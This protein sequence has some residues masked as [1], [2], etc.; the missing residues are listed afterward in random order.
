M[1]VTEESRYVENKNFNSII[2]NINYIDSN[3]CSTQIS[4]S[5]EDSK[6]NSTET[7]LTDNLS[8]IANIS[9]TLTL[10]NNHQ[11]PHNRT[12]VSILFYQ[13]L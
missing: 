9:A 4:N 11:S 12:P 1:S 5:K 13:F 2:L 8:P 3:Y 10:L 6:M 7:V